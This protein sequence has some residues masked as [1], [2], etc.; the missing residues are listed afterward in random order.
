MAAKKVYCASRSLR[1]R[2]WDVPEEVS[3][4]PIEGLPDEVTTI[5]A[6]R[7]ID[8]VQEYLTP[9][10]KGSMPDPHVLQD[11]EKAAI[12]TANAVQQGEKIALYGDYDVDGATSTAI[13]KRF[14]RGLDLGDVTV[15]IP[16]RLT[17]GYGPNVPAMDKL[18]AEGVQLL[19]IVDSGSVAF[20]PVAKARELGM[21]V[22]VIDHHECEVQK[23]SAEQCDDTVDLNGLDADEREFV[24]R[25]AKARGGVPKLPDALVVNPKRADEDRSL[26]YLCSAGLAFLFAVAVRRVLRERSHF[27]GN[28]EPDLKPLLGIVAL[29][30]VA[31]MVPLTGLNR[32]YVKH[33]LPLMRL[34]PGIDALSEVI[35]RR[36][37]EE[38]PKK[39][40]R[41]EGKMSS[42]Y[43]CG[44]LYGPCINAAGRIDDTSL[45]SLLLSTD[46]P[47]E[48]SELA[49][50]LHGLNRERQNMQTAMIN[51]AIQ[52]VNERHMDDEVLVVYDETWHPGVV[53]LVASRLKEN[54]DKS[55]FVIGA[56]GK[57]SARAAD[58]FDVGRAVIDARLSGLLLKGGGHK[59]AAGLSCDPKKL[60]SFRSFMCDRAKGFEPP[61]SKV[62]LVVEC[63]AV[64][65]RAIEA[66]EVLAPFGMGN[67]NPR[68][69]VVGGYLEKVIVLKG[70]HIKGFLKSDHGTV[71]IIMFG[72]V[73]TPTGERILGS[74]GYYMDV[75]GRLEI[76]TFRGAKKVQVVP[77]D[78]MIG[79][80]A[81]ADE[82]SAE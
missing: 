8:D 62:D 47:E 44:F 81:T 79:N 29:G 60:N 17:E 52:M 24:S 75:L 32:A 20:E 19:I 3:Y 74:Q 10:L 6:R 56:G 31:D 34:N 42:A 23:S 43:A 25:T 76:N 33:G 11:M 2:K 27:E 39:A 58:G 66:M 30:T 64:D 68:T 5:I 1:G 14:F 78:V 80:V 40:E 53:G 55:A 18:K 12:R 82:A 38:D 70:K 63:G 67:P 37:V 57:G 36:A 28:R 73:D 48:A 9:T 41:L 4:T 7:D 13:L 49:D 59:A 71:E 72:A 61:A 50:R 26:E 15:Y 54:F 22:I 69:A 77:E 35:L 46:N 45:G 21:D 51:Q 16:D 65:A